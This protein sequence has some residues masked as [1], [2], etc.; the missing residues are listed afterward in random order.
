MSSTPRRNILIAAAGLAVLVAAPTARAN[1]L[2]AGDDLTNLSL[3]ALMNVEVTSVTR[4]RT[5]IADAPAAVYVVSEEDIRRSGA[6]NVPEAL[7]MVPGM[8]VARVSASQWAVGSRGFHDLYNKSLLVLQDGRTLYNPFFSGVLWDQQENF[9]A[10]LSRIEVVRGPGATLWGANAVNGVINISS[11]PANETQGALLQA[12]IGDEEHI[13]AVRYGGKIGGDTFY[14]VWTR[15]RDTDD[16][17]LFDDT[18]GFDGW[19]D[20]HSGFRIDKYPSPDDAL[21]LQGEFF[22]NTI[23][24]RVV[25]PMFAPPF[26]GIDQNDF[27][28]FGGHVLGRWRHVVDEESDYT[29]QAY[30]DAFNRDDPILGYIQHTF[31][32]DFQHRFRL[33]ERQQII[34]GGGYRFQTDALNDNPLFRLDPDHFDSHLLSA[35]VQDNIALVPTKLHLFLGSKF[36]LNS[37]SGFEVQPSARLL[38]TPSDRHSV[39]G[40]VSRAVRTPNRFEKHGSLALSRFPTP[41]GIPAELRIEGRGGTVAEELIAL[42][43][44]YRFQAGRSFAL[45]VATFANRYDHLTTFA[46]G[47]PSF[48]PTGPVPHLVIPAAI[49]N[50]AEAETYGLEVA[51][52][53]NVT[54]NWNLHASYTLFHAFQHSLTADDEMGAEGNVPHNQFH[55]RSHLDVTRDVEFNASAYYVDRLSFGGIDPYVRIDANVVWRPTKGVELQAGVFNAFDGEHPEFNSPSFRTVPTQPE[56][57]VWF[58]ASFRF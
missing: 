23:G 18:E 49:A 11:K 58:Q 54:T 12:R 4:Q 47:T 3:E 42:E 55:V 38:W 26:V 7:R 22:N 19:D 15:Y 25:V 35:F 32:V 1:T 43:A 52:T 6:T 31:D 30:Y 33:T 13:G 36:E 41:Q 34:W 2:E 9:M 50:A 17:P 51:S 5:R 45:D 16:Q 37:Y 10:D 8:M 46:P 14:R 56:R 29:I 53:L 48:D 40:S 20:L 39:W 44:G 21:T 57:A 27:T 24:Q 28:V